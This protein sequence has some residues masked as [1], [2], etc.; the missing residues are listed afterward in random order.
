M[1]LTNEIRVFLLRIFNRVF[2]I[3]YVLRLGFVNTWQ[4]Q[5]HTTT[6]NFYTRWEFLRSYRLNVYGP[7]SLKQETLRCYVEK[8]ICFNVGIDAIVISSQEKSQLLNAQDFKECIAK[9]SSHKLHIL[10]WMKVVYKSSVCFMN[11]CI[12]ISSTRSNTGFSAMMNNCTL[13]TT[14]FATVI[15]R[16]SNESFR[17]LILKLNWFLCV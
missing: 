1:T 13:C 3:H 8:I 12:V 15:K 7:V 11:E 6:A 5:A 16:I 17:F 9:H 4:H 14:L 2:L 10:P